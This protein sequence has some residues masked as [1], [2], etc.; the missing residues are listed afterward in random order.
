VLDHVNIAIIR[1]ERL[2]LFDFASRGVSEHMWL[3]QFDH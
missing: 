2:T 1:S 3:R